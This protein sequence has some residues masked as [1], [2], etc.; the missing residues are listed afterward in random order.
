MAFTPIIKLKLLTP[1]QVKQP[2]ESAPP[3]EGGTPGLSPL[4]HMWGKA[5]AIPRPCLCAVTFPTL[6]SGPDYDVHI[7]V[8]LLHHGVMAPDCSTLCS[9]TLII[10]WAH[11]VTASQPWMLHCSLVWLVAR[12][13]FHAPLMVSAYRAV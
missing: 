10:V 7:L 1:L 12:V 13:G 6:D 8:S 3:A 11:H 9:A 2:L 4:E 5:K